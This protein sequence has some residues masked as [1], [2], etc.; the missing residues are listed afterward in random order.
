MRF[1]YELYEPPD[2]EY[3]SLNDKLEWTGVMKELVERVKSYISIKL[4]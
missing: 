3:G 4:S 1:D 2:G